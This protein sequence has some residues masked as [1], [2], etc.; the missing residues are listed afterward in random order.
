MSAMSGLTRSKKNVRFDEMLRDAHP[1]HFYMI[2][3]KNP[4]EGVGC[5]TL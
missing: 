3:I 4:L 5:V 1:S 2:A